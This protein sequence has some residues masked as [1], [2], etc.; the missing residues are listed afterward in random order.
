[1]IIIIKASLLPDVMTRAR[2]SKINQQN[3]NSLENLK[4]KIQQI[5]KSDLINQNALKSPAPE[6]KNYSPAASGSQSLRYNNQTPKSQNSKRTVTPAKK[7]IRNS[8]KIFSG[9]I[10]KTRK[11]LAVIDWHKNMRRE[12]AAG[13]RVAVMRKGKNGQYALIGKL[14]IVKI[15]KNLSLV[16]RYAKGKYI[17]PPLRASDKVVAVL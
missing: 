7:T 13:T 9:T 3:R 11:D 8:T 6:T 1:L 12:L 16:K 15:A 2:E 10:R 14:E 5:K 4:L 17:C